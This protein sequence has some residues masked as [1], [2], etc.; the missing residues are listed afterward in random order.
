[1]SIRLPEGRLPA[2][3]GSATAEAPVE[4]WAGFTGILSE[5]F[6][7]RYMELVNTKAYE[8]MVNANPHGKTS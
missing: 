6:F 3:R 1:M 7:Y 5:V 8:N 2:G 4:E